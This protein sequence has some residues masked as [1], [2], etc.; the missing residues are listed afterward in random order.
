MAPPAVVG[1]V[2][3]ATHHVGPQPVGHGNARF[4]DPGS[5]LAELSRL[6]SNPFTSFCNPAEIL[7]YERFASGPPD[8][9]D[10]KARRDRLAQPLPEVGLRRGYQA[11]TSRT[12]FVASSGGSCSPTSTLYPSVV[13]PLSSLTRSWPGIMA[14]RAGLGCGPLC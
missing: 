10:R 1:E 6:L 13:M 14:G 9:P 8:L 12:I 7:A 3:G 4:A 11:R 2:P 5:V